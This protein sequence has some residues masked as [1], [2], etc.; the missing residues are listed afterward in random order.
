MSE[1]LS[2]FDMTGESSS[3]ALHSIKD[4]LFTLDHTLRRTMDSG[5]PPQ[6]MEKALAAREAVQAAAAILEKLF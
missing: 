3:E 5:L 6:D 1:F 2:V 4:E